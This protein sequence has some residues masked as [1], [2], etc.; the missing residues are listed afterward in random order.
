MNKGGRTLVMER[1]LA[2]FREAL[3]LEGEVVAMQPA[4][5]GWSL[6][7]DAAAENT[8]LAKA[9]LREIRAVF[10]VEVDREATVQA[11][12]RTALREKGHI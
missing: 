2:F 6:R 9:S 1:V 5:R 7:V 4:G 3:G 11:F 12:R 10:Q 8:A